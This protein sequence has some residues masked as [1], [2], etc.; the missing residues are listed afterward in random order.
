M[1]KVPFIFLNHIQDPCSNNNLFFVLIF[2]H[3]ITI[4]SKNKRIR[5]VWAHNI[6]EEM[7][8]ISDLIEQYPCVAMDTEFPG[9]IGQVAGDFPNLSEFKYQNLKFNVDNL[10]LIQLGITLSD[11]EGNLPEGICTWQFNCKFNINVDTY[12]RDSVEL[13]TRSGINFQKTINEGIDF[14]TLGSY[15]ISSGLVLS[16]N[17]FWITFHAYYDFGYLIKFLTAKILPTLRKDFLQDLNA[18]FPNIYDIKYLLIPSNNHH[19]GLQDIA[20]KVGVKRFGQ[21]HQ[22]GSDSL[23]TS[24]T[25]FKIKELFFKNK[26][27]KN[28]KGKVYGL[29]D[30]DDIN[31]VSSTSENKS[32]LN[33]DDNKEN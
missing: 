3:S 19:Y 30:E 24:Q 12:S 5:D 32:S 17:V 18:F 8:V 9:V 20:N 1:V 31:E 21:Q 22:A 23:I 27:N 29:N 28:L 26:I 33:K 6:E 25:F 4:T 7:N 13:L 14:E 16:E 2:L 10:K 15:F 11:P